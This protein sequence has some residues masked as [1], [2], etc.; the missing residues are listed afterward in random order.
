[1]VDLIVAW[2]NA[3]S[4]G[5]AVDYQNL[6]TTPQEFNGNVYNAMML[7]H[8]TAVKPVTSIVLA[9]ISS[10]LLA[11]TSAR[12]DGDRELGTRI[13]SVTMFKIVM[14]FVVCQNAPMILNALAEVSAWMSTVVNGLDVGADSP[15]S[16]APL[17][18]QMR[19]AIDEAGTMNQLVMILILLLPWIV[20]AFGTVIVGVLILIRF[21]QMYLLGAFAS[22]PVVFLMHEDT[23]QIGIGFLKRFSVVAISGVVIVLAL[24]LYQALLAGAMTDT[25]VYDGGNV[26]PFIASNFAGFLFSAIILIF[27]MFGA[28]NIAKAIIGEG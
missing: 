20:S 27:L 28:N 17:G 19:G 21:L 13:I 11:S 26:L 1:V 12:T 9:I 18:D 2:L 5:T 4:T 24:K 8:S 15:T 22:L 3:L 7:V 10:M 16:G 23:K 14:V 25:I 6:L